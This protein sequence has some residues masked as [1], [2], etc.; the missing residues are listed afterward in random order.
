MY[1]VSYKRITRV[2]TRISAVHIVQVQRLV[3]VLVPMAEMQRLE[4]GLQ[5]DAAAD[6]SALL[7]SSGRV[8]GESSSSASPSSSPSQSASAKTPSKEAPNGGGGGGVLSKPAHTHTQDTLIVFL[9]QC[10]FVLAHAAARASYESDHLLFRCIGSA[11][12]VAAMSQLIDALREQISKHDTAPAT[13]SSRYIRSDL[14]S[15]CSIVSDYIRVHSHVRLYSYCTRI[16][17]TD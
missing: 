11:E 6:G 10:P 5:S 12:G 7:E 13:A 15:Q 1:C 3:S 2:D 14:Y 4:S 16:L 17:N 8:A 9:K